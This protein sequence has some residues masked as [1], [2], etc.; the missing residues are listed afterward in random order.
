MIIL[1]MYGKA[2]KL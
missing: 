2:C 1:V